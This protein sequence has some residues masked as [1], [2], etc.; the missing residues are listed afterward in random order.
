MTPLGTGMLWMLFARGSMNFLFV[1]R[2][3][4]LDEW[5]GRAKDP[6]QWRMRKPGE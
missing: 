5:P 2:L 1:E 3:A 4:T 6:R